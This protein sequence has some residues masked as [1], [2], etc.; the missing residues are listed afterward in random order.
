MSSVPVAP[1]G[2]ATVALLHDGEQVGGRRDRAE[3]Q[4][5]T[6]TGLE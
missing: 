4:G 2:G 6:F 5:A 3:P 1:H